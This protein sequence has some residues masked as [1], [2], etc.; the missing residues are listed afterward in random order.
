MSLRDRQV[1]YNTSRSSFPE[2]L[3]HA[4]RAGHAVERGLFPGLLLVEVRAGHDL[5]VF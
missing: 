3:R 2:Q 5:Y 4:S 1:E